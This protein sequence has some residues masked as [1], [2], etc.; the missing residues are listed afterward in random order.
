ML[1]DA[2]ASKKKL[3]HMGTWGNGPFKGNT[4]EIIHGRAAFLVPSKSLKIPKTDNF[5][6]SQTAEF[7]ALTSSA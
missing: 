1:G 5:C 4:K 7:S 3:S 2:I 6:D